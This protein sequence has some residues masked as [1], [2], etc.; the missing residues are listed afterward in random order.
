M[1][2][3]RSFLGSI[4]GLI[5]AQPFIAKAFDEPVQLIEG[6]KSV[7][8]DYKILFKDEIS[9]LFIQAPPLKEI[10]KYTDGWL[11][12]INEMNVT[13]RITV[14]HFQLYN[15][16][17]KLIKEASLNRLLQMKNGDTFNLFYKL[18]FDKNME[19]LFNV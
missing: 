10:V 12:E 17:N 16:Y 19:N 14:Q 11:F 7:T 1:T 18:L 15:R 2:S 8:Y 5:G 13:K 6:L 9:S 4:L 3:R